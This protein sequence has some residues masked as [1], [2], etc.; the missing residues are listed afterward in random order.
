MLLSLSIK[1]LFDNKKKFL[2][3]HRTRSRLL[4]Y[5]N[6][7][8]RNRR[9]PLGDLRKMFFSFIASF[10]IELY[11]GLNV[12]YRSIKCIGS[13][14]TLPVISLWIWLLFLKKKERLEWSQ[15][16]SHILRTER[17]FFERFVSKCLKLKAS[18]SFTVILKLK[19]V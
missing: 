17:Y 15:E 16:K 4:Y 11:T 14:E 3:N 12:D 7:C 19:T 8:C 18:K 10:S 9:I 1:L 2:K 6:P 13:S 5:P